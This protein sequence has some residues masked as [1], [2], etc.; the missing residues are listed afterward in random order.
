MAWGP[1]VRVNETTRASGVS[2]QWV[3]SISRYV[4][5]ERGRVTVTKQPNSCS[6]DT[7]RINR[8]LPLSGAPDAFPAERRT[9]HRPTVE[10]QLPSTKRAL[11]SSPY[12]YVRSFQ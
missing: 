11:E 12:R 8:P 9:A 5:F 2:E 4:Y 1:P 7:R 6:F 10:Y 3:Y